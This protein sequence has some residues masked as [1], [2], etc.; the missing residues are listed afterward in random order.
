MSETASAPARSW[1]DIANPT[2]F[3]A[4]ADRAIPWL[5]VLSGVVLALGLYL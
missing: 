2:R 5:A 3:V 4:L 1:T